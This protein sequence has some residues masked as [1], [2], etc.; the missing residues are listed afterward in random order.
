M[1]SWYAISLTIFIPYFRD[2]HSVLNLG[3]R[4]P[5]GAFFHWRDLYIGTEVCRYT[6]S[7]TYSKKS[8]LPQHTTS[9][10]TIIHHHTP[11]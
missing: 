8:T 3:E 7:Y 5:T 2:F 6:Y 9:Y 1:Y 4:P 10:Y 11:S